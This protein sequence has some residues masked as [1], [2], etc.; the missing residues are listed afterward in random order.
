MRY[1]NPLLFGFLLFMGLLFIPACNNESPSN[2]PP[3]QAVSPGLPPAEVLD[4]DKA[5]VRSERMEVEKEK[6]QQE[7]L[8]RAE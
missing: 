6:E 1:A 3:H 2:E 7:M 5:N 8:E 4:P